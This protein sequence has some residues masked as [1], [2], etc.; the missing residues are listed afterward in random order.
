MQEEII[1]VGQMKTCACLSIANWCHGSGSCFF[2][3]SISLNLSVLFFFFK[4]SGCVCMGFQGV[5]LTH[6]GVLL[7]I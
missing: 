5:Y 1:R 3:V 4:S 7:D 2:I 6:T